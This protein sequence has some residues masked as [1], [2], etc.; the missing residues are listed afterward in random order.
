MQ[1][2]KKV[3]GKFLFSSP[4]PHESAALLSQRYKHSKNIRQ[5]PDRLFTIPAVHMWTESQ[6]CWGLAS[7][8][9][10]GTSWEP[11]GRVLSHS[12]RNVGWG[13][14]LAKEGERSFFEER[15]TS[16]PRSATKVK[17]KVLVTQLNPTSC[18]SLWIHGIPQ[19]RTLEWAAI[20]FSRG[21][22]TPRD[23]TWVSGIAS[24]SFTIRT[25]RE[26]LTNWA[27]C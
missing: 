22:S 18:E 11:G 16:F 15:A 9:F 19:A 10:L 3:K 5:N 17:V 25:T 12:S 13:R 6:V 20:P 24:E 23:R 7:F 4:R 8:K 27:S 26:A 1:K 2:K 14:S 21:S